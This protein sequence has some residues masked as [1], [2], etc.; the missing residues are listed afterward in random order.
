MHDVTRKSGSG[1]W[2][3]Q[4]KLVTV[5][6]PPTPSPLLATVTNGQTVLSLPSFCMHKRLSHSF[7]NKQK[8]PLALL[9]KLILIRVLAN[10]QDKYTHTQAH[11]RNATAAALA[12]VE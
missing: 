4:L 2:R 8:W 7:L 12:S 3:L 1:Q 9:V 5:T 6:A 11:G 10:S